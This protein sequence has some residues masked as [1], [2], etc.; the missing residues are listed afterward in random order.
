MRIA[1]PSRPALAPAVAPVCLVRRCRSITDVD[2]SLFITVSNLLRIS[3]PRVGNL[4][5]LFCRL[6]PWPCPFA[7]PQP[8]MLAPPL[9]TASISS[10]DHCVRQNLLGNSFLSKYSPSLGCTGPSDRPG[11]PPT[12]PYVIGPEVA[13]AK[14]DEEIGAPPPLPFPPPKGPCCWALDRY[15]AKL[16]GRVC[17][18]E[19]G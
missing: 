10:S 19:A 16:S 18:G 7:V 9:L 2:N 4:P 8:N 11:A 17:V 6:N 1:N 13:A 3:T 5:L 12:A 15:W 14:G